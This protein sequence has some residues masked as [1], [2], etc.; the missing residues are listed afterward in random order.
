M[1]GWPCP[2]SSPCSLAYAARCGSSLSVGVVIGETRRGRLAPWGG[3]RRQQFDHIRPLCLNLHIHPSKVMPSGGTEN[4]PCGSRDAIRGVDGVTGRPKW[5][6]RLVG[7]S[8]KGSITLW[9][10][11]SEGA[12][13]KQPC[14]CSPARA[15]CPPPAPR[16]SSLSRRVSGQ[17]GG[18]PTRNHAEPTPI[19][20][21]RRA[22]LA[23][24]PPFF[25]LH[26]AWEQGQ[27]RGCQ[28][29]DH[30]EI[31]G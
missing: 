26:R 30:A 2:L 6:A 11:A 3:F 16:H 13:S 4:L 7:H 29:P 17:R 14:S 19:P 8:E 24:P 12:P 23:R 5:I 31:G 1:T 18:L 28:V 20:R 25:L 9:P 21:G 10:D 15:S 27:Q 22:S